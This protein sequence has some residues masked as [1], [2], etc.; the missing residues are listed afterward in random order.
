VAA[1]AGDQEN[2]RCCSENLF[3]FHVGLFCQIK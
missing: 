1:N 3:D 2:E